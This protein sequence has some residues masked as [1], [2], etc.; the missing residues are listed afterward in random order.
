MAGGLDSLVGAM[1]SARV[2]DLIGAVTASGSS[3][4]AQTA[5][6][7]TSA[8]Q[9]A[10]A[11]T[12]AAPP[13]QGAALAPSVQITFSQLAMALDAISR[14]GGDTPPPVQG[15]MP[16]WATPPGAPGASPSSAA[17]VPQP[18]GA[19]AQTAPAATLQPALVPLLE[20]MLD[21]DGNGLATGTAVTA[22]T[23]SKADATGTAAASSTAALAANPQAG[24][25]VSLAGALAQALESSG[26]FY[27]S[28]LAQWVA[29]ARSS[30]E[31]QRE[32]QAQITTNQLTFDFFSESA[33]TLDANQPGNPAAAN[34]DPSQGADT[35]TAAAA[36]PRLDI[37]AATLPLVRQQLDMLSTA[38]PVFRWS[39]EA[40]PGAKLDWEVEPYAAQGQDTD[41]SAHTWRTR[42]TLELPTLGSVDTELV[43]AGRQL[44]ARIRANPDGAATLLHGSEDLR[45][46]IAAAGLDLSKLSIREQTPG[47]GSLP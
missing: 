11:D 19:A 13:A 40:W 44:L 41:E 35:T 14:L 17:T 29:G 21:G 26:L 46:R 47:T 25:A 37:N 24:L 39:G 32:P 34:G 28:H 5:M 23:V 38:Q 4:T 8:A 30:A 27:E 36:T 42:V 31:L 15:Q 43:L 33:Q 18:T 45:R 12:A 6:A 16:L 7:Q 22:A 9:V 10:L 20:A 1:L 3:T 2:D